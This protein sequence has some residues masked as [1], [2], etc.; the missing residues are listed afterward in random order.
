MIV[1]L[2]KFAKNQIRSI[3]KCLLFA[4]MKKMLSAPDFLEKQIVVI[5]SDQVKDLMLRNDNLLIKENDKIVNQ[6]SCFKIFCIF[7][8]GEYTISSK[9][10]DRLAKYQIC[11][12]CLW[13]NLKPKVM[14]GN[15][16]QGNY[17]LR[18]K[19]Y[20]Q[21]PEL[22]I[23]KKLITN[24]IQNQLSLLQEIREKSDA[25]KTNLLRIKELLPKID[26]AEND[27]SLRGLEGNA[28]KLFFASYFEEMKWYKRLPRT[29]NDIINFLMDIGYSFLYNFIEA[30]LCLYG[31]DVYKGVYHKLFYERK[32]LACDLVEPFRCIIDKKIRKMHNLGQINEKDF[33]FKNGEY[34]IDR[35]KQKPYIQHFL[36]ALLEQKMEIFSYIKEYYRY[37][38]DPQRPFPTFTFWEK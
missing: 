18:Q 7:I 3:L 32:S 25:Y 16:L 8:V 10:I 35:E 12:F 37:C 17:L 27:D 38:M 5:T 13:Y 11:I 22:D 1:R 34:C 15:A 30:N 23:A 31:F 19:Q 33:K 2:P 26:Q 28:S 29:R 4:K 14:I 36:S 6:I 21:L 20:G 9:L 24:K